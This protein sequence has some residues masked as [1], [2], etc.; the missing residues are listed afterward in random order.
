MLTNVGQLLLRRELRESTPDETRPGP[1]CR[2]VDHESL[3]E[4]EEVDI[5]DR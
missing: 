1:I 3:H 2:V 5:V 4:C